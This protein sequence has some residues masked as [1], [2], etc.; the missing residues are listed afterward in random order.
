MNYNESVAA[1]TKTLLMSARAETP[2]RSY[3]RQRRRQHRSWVL[4]SFASVQVFWRGGSTLFIGKS[5]VFGALETKRQRAAR[6][7]D[8]GAGSCAPER[9]SLRNLIV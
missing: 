6:V 1:A 8:V 3:R 5:S 2:S 7:Q 4:R 9:G